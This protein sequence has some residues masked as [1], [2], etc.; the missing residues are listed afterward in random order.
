MNNLTFKKWNTITGWCL[1]AIAVIVYSLTV[2]PSFSFWDCGE[3]ISTSAKLQVG[4]PPGAP[5]F[6]I[7]GAVFAL[8]ATGPD[9]V[10]LMVNMVSVLSSA[11]TILFMFWS[12][13]IVLKNTVASYSELNKDTTVMILGASAVGSL[14]FL[15]SDSFWFNATEA[16]VYAMASLFIALLL[17]AGL[18]W[19][20]EM[21]TPRG[22]K[23]LL[24]I[25][26]LIGLSFGVHFMALLAI[27]SLGLI[28]FFKNYKLVTVKNF[29]IANIVMILVLFFVFGFLL[30]YTLALFGKT[31]I[32]MVNS[33]GM[34]FNSGTIFAFLFVIAFF[35]FG[36]RFTQK[37]NLPVYNTFLLC[38][39]FIFIGF[40]TWMILPIRA[41]ANV[42]INENNP[43]NAADVLAYYNREQ[44]P[45]QRTFYGPMY[46]EAY[47]G[48]DPDTPFTDAKP[49]Y[50]RNEKTGRYEIVNNYINAKQNPNESQSG[51]LPR[52]GSTDHAVNYMSFA[53]APKF[54]LNP[55]YDFSEDLLRYG[56][57][58]DKLSDEQA[59]AAIAQAR[60]QLEQAIGEFKAA[61]AKGEVGNEEYNE[62][63]KN[64]KDYL[65]VEKPSFAQNMAFMF[66]YQ[67][68]YM[69]WRYLMWNFSGR[70]SDE[71]GK[72]DNIN[73]N[74]ISGIKFIDEA[75]LGPQDHL[76]TIMKN[77]KGRNAY[78]LIPFILGV[79]GMVFHARKERKSFYVLLLL[80]LFTGIALKIF[81]NERPFE[82]RE[83]DYAL[84][85]SFYVFALWIGFG[86]YS[87]FD[88]I[89]K[90]IQPKIAVPA[91]LAVTLLAAPVLMA[92]ENWD[93]HDRSSRYTAVA[94]AKAYLD[95]CEPN[96]ILF[97]IGDN[98][99]FPL[100]CAQEIEG[101][102]TDVRI[103]CSTLFP[104]DWYID[105]MK[106]Q[107][108]KS[109]P[110]PLSFEHSQYVD[111]TRD[112]MLYD[113]RTEERIS[114]DD[115]MKFIKNDDERAMVELK[116]G[117]KAHI[118]PSN[119]IRFPV[120]KNAVIANRA[121]A[122]KYY[123]SIVPFIDVDLP[124]S[125][126]YK[127][128]LMMLDIVRNNNWKRPIYFSGG[129]FDDENYIWMKDYLQLQ[130][131][132]L[133]LVPIKTK[134]PKDG[135][136]MD[137][138]F[139]DT[140]A[141]YNVVT[142]WDWGN[143]GTNI[144]HDP[145]TRINGISFRKNMARLMDKLIREKKFDK[146]RKV[147]DMAMTKMPVK[148]FG[149]YFMVEPFAGG[150]YQTGQKAAARKLL[151]ELITIYREKLEYYKSLPQSKQNTDYQDIISDIGSYR[152][153]L[154][155]M[156][157]NGD[158]EFYNQSKKQFNTCNSWF[159]QFERENE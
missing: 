147:I 130:G 46:T 48:L 139:I 137:M 70:Q 63:L 6:Q 106:R 82:V 76:T 113:L 58:L 18:R 54:K 125:A 141:M 42:V 37:K 136:V 67:F 79:M 85:G 89:T 30:P 109:A 93:D 97:T 72:Y 144:Y 28:Y 118:Y 77:N 39:L 33:L 149:F 112:Y 132:A 87:I 120:D 110:V 52:M 98:D 84:V 107:T 150:Y 12:L 11:F 38:I 100:W 56:V 62:F 88:G 81:L 151:T 78:Y 22:N 155:V 8:F 73:G 45:Q 75:R 129:S 94:M 128:N 29:I 2:E 127:H 61:Y 90:Y 27:P 133:K 123:D 41:N 126:I 31:E 49:N 40:S 105:Q 96:A 25:S 68:G 59:G 44:Y 26:L 153:L 143:S 17:W 92:K 83:R 53:G 146:A 152:S 57:D 145:Q 16:E 64:Y 140:D 1:F 111:G 135:T 80:F 101:Y 66:E 20:E 10:S 134:I 142:K 3:Y 34:P 71:Q 14:A 50:E 65:V 35:Y 148:E 91:V 119:K 55:A 21:H 7:V 86:V 114:I 116:G 9:K 36:L 121:V 156:Q 103:V 13:T 115:F 108:Y 122:P 104:T 124:K 19:G 157:E 154:L 159:P 60:G 69:Y 32:F 95:S 138:G 24:I 5:L 47:V 15:F 23:W 158:T 99:T 74:W 131:V 4:H 51:F 102:R 43:A 117:Q